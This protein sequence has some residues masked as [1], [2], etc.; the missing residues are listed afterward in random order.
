MKL[1]DRLRQ[2][3]PLMSREEMVEMLRPAY[4][5]SIDIHRFLR[6]NL[7]LMASKSFP[8]LLA[9]PTMY[10]RPRS[11]PPYPL[12]HLVLCQPMLPLLLAQN[13]SRPL[14]PTSR[15]HQSSSFHQ[16]HLLLPRLLYRR[17]AIE[18]Q[19]LIAIRFLPGGTDSWEHRP[20]LPRRS[21]ARE[22]VDNNQYA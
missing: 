10:K 1:V 5:V 13:P 9:P 14:D 18:T 15:C 12:L 3:N 20:T 8:R 19:R 17:Q 21:K 22:D 16:S 6:S 4:E 2:A 7:P 11:T